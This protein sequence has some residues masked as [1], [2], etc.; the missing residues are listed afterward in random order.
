MADISSFKPIQTAVECPLL[1]PHTGDELL[2]DNGDPMVIMMLGRDTKEFKAFKAEN[3][4]KKRG[5]SLS[6]GQ[7][8]SLLIELFVN[9]TVEFKNLQ[10]DG[11]AIEYSDETAKSLYKQYSWIRD[12]INAF[13]DDRT[14]FLGNSDK[15]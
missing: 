12:Q 8:E 11:K 13:W 15:A 14:N 3:D 10:L 1:H 2:N 5:K 7:I 6:S 9:V 4:R